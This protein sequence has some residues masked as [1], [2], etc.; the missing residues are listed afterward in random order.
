MNLG[1]ITTVVLCELNWSLQR[2]YKLSKTDRLSIIDDVL[3]AAELEVENETLCRK[4]LSAA[5]KGSADFA[6]Y[7][8]RE[9]ALASGCSVVLTFDKAAQKSEGFEEPR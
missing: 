1:F 6:D 8:I 7:L 5:R 2:A 3:S 9:I 4:A